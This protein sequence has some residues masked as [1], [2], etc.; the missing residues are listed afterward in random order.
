MQLKKFG[1]KI[2]AGVFAGLAMISSSLCAEV[3]DVL[4]LYTPEARNTRNGRDIQARISAYMAYAN[5]AYRNSHV[6]I[7]LR[8]VGTAL[9]DLPYERV[10]E[11]NLS[12][13]ARDAEVARLREETGADLVT[14]LNLRDEVSGNY[15]CG[16]GYIPQGRSDTGRFYS[17]AP[18]GAFS[19]VGI[20]CDVATFAHEL[21]HNMGL[22]HSLRQ[23]SAGGVWPWARGHGVD[24]LFSTIMA[25]PHFYGTQNQLPVFSNPDIFECAGLPCGVDR[26]HTD[27]AHAAA[28]L[29][30]LASQISS[31]RPTVIADTQLPGADDPV[32]DPLQKC[33][34]IPVSQNLLRNGD[35]D[36]LEAWLPSLGPATLS[37]EVF[38]AGNCLE[39]R[40]VVSDRT[41]YYS[42]VAQ[43][44]A[45]PLPANVTYQF[46]GQFGIRGSARENLRVALLVRSDRG[47]TYHYL[48]TLSVT[49]SEMTHF[50]QSFSVPSGQVEGL[51]VYGPPGGVDIV[52]DKMS[53]IRTF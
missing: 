16:I 1:R 27:G 11:E 35:F 19:L 23:N 52:V 29:T 2:R 46:K 26:N 10:S 24:G 39:N 37:I 41:V 42:S 45:T 49:A 32:Q 50:T 34:S 44:F 38:A 47:S 7:Q 5:T 3:V 9:M 13:F 53:L 14:L 48:N 28:N 8:L 21:G 18:S 20:E 36:S 40:L 4:V 31:F 12:N 6:D 17:N 51:L 43:T 25:Y 30:A 15:M 22:G 33:A